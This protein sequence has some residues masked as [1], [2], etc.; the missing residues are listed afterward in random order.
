MTRQQNH[1]VYIHH[2]RN[3]FL[4]LNI[5]LEATM[6]K[7]ALILALIIIPCSAFGLEMLND[8]TMDGITA[9][10]GINI[11]VDDIQ[12]FLNI[13]KMAWID[14]DGFS[15]LGR[16]A[17][18]GKGGALALNNFQIDV[19]N[20]NAIVGSKAGVQGNGTSAYGGVGD[21]GQYGNNLGLISTTCGKIPLF[22][23]YAT[24]TQLGCGLADLAGRTTVGLDN[25]Y[26]HTGNNYYF[27]PQFLSIDATDDLPA[28]T[29]GLRTWNTNPWTSFAVA[30]NGGNGASSVGGVLIGLPTVE[31]YINDMTFT[32]VYDGDL[33]NSTSTAIN[34]D[35]NTLAEGGFSDFG[36]IQMHG[37]T[38][39]VLSG[40]IEIS[41]K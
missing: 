34:D 37:I 2:Y 16:I 30:S 29:Q 35:D 32:P 7:L 4:Y 14:C 12:L 20:I 17:C 38:F 21:G 8:E 36:T 13:E 24:D 40:W 18:S 23:N 22:Y 1:T 10:A 31:I 19:L 11:A 6:K 26:G 27:T 39:T 9:Q 15:S 5:Y 41:P 33:T 3:N 25:Y 28:S